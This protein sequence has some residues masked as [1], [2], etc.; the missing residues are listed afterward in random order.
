MISNKGFQIFGSLAQSL[1]LPHNMAAWFYAHLSEFAAPHVLYS[2]PLV[3]LRLLLWTTSHCAS[4][5]CTSIS[6]GERRRKHTSHHYNSA[7]SNSLQVAIGVSEKA[8][9]CFYICLVSFCESVLTASINVAF[10]R[11]SCTGCSQFSALLTQVTNSCSEV[12]ANISIRR[13]DSNVDFDRQ[14][15]LLSING[16]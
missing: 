14:S 4:R 11:A 3:W 16:L 12:S 7:T 6:Y 13:R 8:V 5:K 1:S 15:S 2:Q 9:Q 10:H